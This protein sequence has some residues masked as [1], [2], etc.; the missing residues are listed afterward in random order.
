[1][2]SHRWGDPDEEPLLS[3]MNG[4]VYEMR[5]PPEITEAEGVLSYRMGTGHQVFKTSEWFTRGWTLQELLAPSHVQFYKADWTSITQKPRKHGNYSDHRRIP[6][7]KGLLSEATGIPPRD[8]VEFTPGLVNIRERLRWAAHR[9]TTKVE[10]MAYS[11]MGLFGISL[12]ILYGEKQWA[13]A[14]LQRELVRLTNDPG[15]FD[16]AG[17]PS[18]L[19]TMLAGNPSAFYDPP[20]VHPEHTSII[21]REDYQK[22]E[23]VL[24]M[25]QIPDKGPSTGARG[26]Q[27]EDETA[28]APVPSLVR[29]M[30]GSWKTVCVDTGWKAPG[31]E[32]V[33]V[34]SPDELD[35]VGEDDDHRE[36]GQGGHDHRHGHG[37]RN[38][39]VYHLG[40]IVDEHLLE[41]VGVPL[42]NVPG[43]RSSDAGSVY[44]SRATPEPLAELIRA[45]RV[46]FTSY[47]L[48]SRPDGHGPVRKMQTME[49]II[50]KISEGLCLMPHARMVTL[51]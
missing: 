26:H 3:H 15:L 19:N 25:L 43:A 48:L 1:M 50:T 30:R 13:F 17:P 18:K 16:W 42:G 32:A 12:P 5:S 41:T 47:L 49:R 38:R 10:D 6:G 37:Q 24:A 22:G 46:P 45:L 35:E 2:L 51:C 8:I 34:C 9:E 44:G 27:W 20:V 36:G 39:Y 28:D 11:I 14:R 23:Q 40:R 33:S 31:L 4:N 7:I 29:T 21:T